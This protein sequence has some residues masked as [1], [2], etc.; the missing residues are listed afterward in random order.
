MK[1]R[2]FVGIMLCVFGILSAQQSFAQQQ[3]TGYV[4]NDKTN[5][6]IEG[7]NVTNSKGRGTITDAK[8]IFR[9]KCSGTVR[10]TVSHIGYRTFRKTIENC[11]GEL[12]V[13]L[14]PFSYS[15]QKISVTDR[16][17]IQV[18]ASTGSI[19]KADLEKQS[20]LRLESALNTLPGIEMQSRSPWGGQRITIRGYY[21]NAGNNTNFNGLG[22]QLYLNNVP[23][24]DASGTTIMDDIDFSSLGQV[25]VIKGPSPLFGNGIAGTVQLYSER[26]ERNGTSLSEQLV[27]GSHGLLRNN[28]TI[29]TKSA[30]TDLRFNYGYQ[31]YNGFRAHDDSGK[32]YVSING[33]FQVSDNQMISAYFSY[34]N[35]DEQLAGEI[36]STDFY[37]RRAI[38]N[39]NYVANNSGVEIESFRTGITSLHSFNR[40]LDNRT[41]VFA[42]GNTLDQNFAH[43]FN[44][45]NNLNFGARTDFTYRQQFEKVGLNGHLG[46]FLQKTNE[47]VNGVF[48]PPFISPPFT[49]STQPQF[50]TDDQNY[51]LNYN[52]FTKWEFLLP[53]DFRVAVG[54]NVNFNKFGIRD[55]LNNGSLY[56]GSTTRS[57]SFDPTFSPSISVLKSFREN[58]SVYAGISTGQT[59]P[60]LSDIIASDGTVNDRL[61]SERAIQY[62]IGS[63]GN[64][65]H[66]R[67]SYQFALFDLEITDRLVT[68]YDNSIAYTTNAGKQRNRGL[69][70]SLDYKV[71]ENSD[72][73]LSLFN[74]WLS[75]TYSD[76]TYT[77]F[78]VYAQNTAGND[79]TAADYSGN[80][81]AGVAPNM[82]DLGIDLQTAPGFYLHAKYQFMDK[83]PVT[84]D[85][86][87]SLKAY[88]LLGG[89]I[90]FKRVLGDYIEM[91]VFAGANNLTGSTHYSFV[92]VGQNISSLGDGYILPAPYKATFY[93]GA[94]LKYRF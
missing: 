4:F 58:V 19:S 10:I 27:G 75:Y 70:L 42:T 71:I 63:K 29:M 13:P 88:N 76:F 7:A 38:A 94:T 73:P 47:S 32:D 43:G 41:T 33:N 65:L 78:K 62:E 90:G 28:T 12:D 36:D 87:H 92:F 50:P 52:F 84:F 35:S 85:N 91:D 24:T 56:N 64:L 54:A 72:A 46:A 20:G 26:P 1:K 11:A 51:A 89:R 17:E 82:L 22:Y 18:A 39:D 6:P 93:G 68:Q 30:H 21:P 48:I 69:E 8:G 3:I 40:Y 59:P 5:E 2:L 31:S 15:L 57:K 80:N 67:L 25:D 66:G 53:A 49:P 45:H 60:L 83:V 14:E 34:N 23:I 61:N 81:V 9:M 16:A 86:R 44:Y 37:G 55:M 74:V 79:S 77:D